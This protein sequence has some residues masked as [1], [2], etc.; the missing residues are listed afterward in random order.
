MT[1]LQEIEK[2]AQ[3]YAKVR[4]NLGDLVNDMQTRIAAVKANYITGI[5]NCVA[6]A[7]SSEADLRAAVSDFPQLFDKPRT[8]TF[9]GIKVGYQKAKG[10][11]TWSDESAVIER[12][13]KLLPAAQ[14]ELL[15][16]AEEK[17]HKPGV[18]DL[19]VADLKRLGIEITD[20]GDVIVIKDTTSEVDKLVDALLK[21]DVES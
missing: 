19:S 21:E 9:H 6:A 15:I 3:Q 12:I 13:R 2:L 20:A 11:V 8:R 17:V 7:K 14:A 5:R 1:A 4:G 10:S 18:Y 16:R